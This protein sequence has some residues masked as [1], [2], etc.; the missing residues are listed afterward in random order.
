MMAGT[1]FFDSID[2]THIHSKQIA[3]I[4]NHFME[5]LI[6]VF[7]DKYVANDKLAFLRK[8]IFVD[9][10]KEIKTMGLIPDTTLKST[11]TLDVLPDK[12][13]IHETNMLDI[14]SGFVS[15]SDSMMADKDKEQYTS[16]PKSKQKLSSKRNNNTPTALSY[17]DTSSNHQKDLNT[18]QH[19]LDISL[20]SSTQILQQLSI[21]E[22]NERKLEESNLMCNGTLFTVEIQLDDWPTDN[23]WELID[24]KTNDI[25]ANVNY[26]EA[27]QFEVVHKEICVEPGPY[28]FT[29]YDFYEDGIHCGLSSCYNISIDNILVIQGSTFQDQISHHH[30]L[31]TSSLCLIDS[32][33]FLELNIHHNNSEFH[34]Y[35][36]NEV[37]GDTFNLIETRIQNDNYTNTFYACL[38]PGIYVLDELHVFDFP[39]SGCGLSDCFQV[40]INNEVIA[41]SNDFLSLAQFGFAISND[42]IAGQRY[43]HR[44]PFLSFIDSV[45][46]FPWNNQ[47]SHIMN[48]IRSLSS[49]EAL[50]NIYTPQYKAACWLLFDDIMKASVEEELTLERYVLGVL[51]Y[52]T[53]QYAEM[54]LSGHYCDLVGVF[55]DDVGH[56]VEINWGEYALIVLMICILLLAI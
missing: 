54:M 20:E 46:D 55:C 48:D 47:T 49:H 9:V 41:N 24:V 11:E 52:S 22:S 29:L 36:R 5:N 40:S 10:M 16:K 4:Q 45:Y 25:I 31:A 23:S 28:I 8:D 53:N 39:T 34:P 56:V 50:S 32:T 37:T 18:K 14:H 35:L 13:L 15:M 3:S 1:M 33:F 19:D 38:L 6:P 30:M 43:C 44:S 26:E 17:I 27:G 2:S 51:L 21:K 42:F 7:D 12:S